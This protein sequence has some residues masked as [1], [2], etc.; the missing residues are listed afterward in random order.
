MT[1]SQET[2]RRLAALLA[3]QQA[4]QMRSER[5]QQRAEA[6]NIATSTVSSATI[7]LSQLAQGGATANQVLA[8][9]SGASEWQPV[10]NSATLPWTSAGDL[11]Y[12]DGGSAQRLGIGAAGQALVVNAGATAPE[13]DTVLTN[14]MTT[15]EDIIVGG[16]SGA[17]AR[18]G[19]GSNGDVLTVSGGSVGWA[20]PSGGGGLTLISSQTLASAATNI[21]FSS[22]PATYT[23]LRVV[24]QGQID[25]NTVDALFLYFNADYTDA[26]Y[27]SRYDLSAVSSAQNAP[28]IGVW[29]GGTRA[30]GGTFANDLD[31]RIPFYSN[32]SLVKRAWSEINYYD[33]NQSGDLV[34]GRGYVFHSG[35]ANTNAVSSLRLSAGTNQFI[36][37][38]VAELYGVL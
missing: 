5:Q 16:A 10:T 27:Q 15:A 4:Q 38:T 19:V 36:A 29:S 18:L 12:Y 8:W 6:G 26:N 23:H 11:L 9:N 34:L 35:A 25:T 24:M 31:I 2:I 32:T 3:A 28:R 14:P 22:I 7:N 37:G 33:D 20:A 30:G 1:N 17:P 13:W 21:D